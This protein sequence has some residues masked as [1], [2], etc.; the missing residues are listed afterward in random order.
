MRFVV[1]GLNGRTGL[2]IETANVELRGNV[3][4]ISG[5]CLVG[6]VE[7]WPLERRSLGLLCIPPNVPRP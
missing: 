4:K 6:T 1:F 3:G 5:V 2:A 7:M